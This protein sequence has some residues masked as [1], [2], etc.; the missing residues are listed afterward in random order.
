VMRHPTGQWVTQQARNL[1]LELDGQ[2]TASG[3]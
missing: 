1:I 2:V 3:S